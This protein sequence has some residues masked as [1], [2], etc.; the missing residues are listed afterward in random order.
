MAELLRLRQIVAAARAR[1]ILY[2]LDEVLQGT[3]TAERRIAAQRILALLLETGSIGAVS[4][5][6]LE[7]LACSP[8]AAAAVNVHVRDQV[9]D[10]PSGPEMTFDYILR[11]G[12]SPTTNALR[13]LAL[14]GLGDSH[15][16][17]GTGPVS[18]LDEDPRRWT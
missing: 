12:I 13:L 1:P 8:V 6:D 14:V 9:I 10:G 4:T 7:L 5:H 18:P 3:N 2:L 15:T 11:P 17:V 16:N